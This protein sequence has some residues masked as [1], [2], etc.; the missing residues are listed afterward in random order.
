MTEKEIKY[1]RHARR[2]MKWRGI[3]ELEVKQTLEEPGKAEL[4]GEGRKNVF[5]MIGSRY[6]KVTYRELKNEILIISVV[7]KSD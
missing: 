4:T 1:D 2:R 3:T 6:I 7:D 5:K